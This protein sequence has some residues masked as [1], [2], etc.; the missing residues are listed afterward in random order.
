MLVV[1]VQ[2]HVKYSMCATGT[3]DV[4][5]TRLG[6]MQRHGDLK[7]AMATRYSARRPPRPSRT[8]EARKINP[9]K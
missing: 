2:R 4:Q 8:K 3:L 6:F 9:K 1:V 7:L 5:K